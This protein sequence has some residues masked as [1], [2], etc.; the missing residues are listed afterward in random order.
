MS[1][2]IIALALAVVSVA[3]IFTAC[4]HKVDLYKINGVEVAVVTDEDDKAV[5]DEHNRIAAVVT[6]R[7]GE[8]V[9]FGNGEPQTYWLTVQ[10]SFVADNTVYTKVYTM[11]GL[12]GWEF[13][14]IGNMVKK[15]TNNQ[16]K[17][18]CGMVIEKE[19]MDKS[20]ED[21]L[22]M[23]D[24]RNAQAKVL[25]ENEGYKVSVEKRVVEAT[26]DKIPMIYYKEIIY[27]SDGSIANY[28]ESL[29]FEY[30]KT[31]KYN[32]HYTCASGVGFDKDFNFLSFVNGHVKIREYED[33]EASS[34]EPTSQAK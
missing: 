33:N 16:C 23:R 3:T 18:Q 2:K 12:D 19:Y 28:S 17:I 7:N 34:T 8:V 9:T 6:D 11:E 31:D 32:I 20:L 26:E 1:K 21:Y 29:Y 5:V 13:D 22:K 25:Y 24:E 14:T 4:R 15:K 10:N 27:N 30:G